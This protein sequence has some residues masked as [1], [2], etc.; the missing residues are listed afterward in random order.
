M[1]CIIISLSMK[2][3]I[4]NGNSVR[5]FFALLCWLVCICVALPTLNSA[6]AS[7]PD[8]A[9]SPSLGGIA[10]LPRIGLE[11]LS[12]N[13]LFD[14]DA[15]SG[16]GF[17]RIAMEWVNIEPDL[18]D[19][20]E[21][22]WDY[23]DYLYAQLAARGITPLVRVQKCPPW[24]CN[25]ANGPILD[26]SYNA[27]GQFMSAV[28]ERYSQP[29]YNVHF[30][31]FWNEPDG[32]GG[33]NNQLGWG[34]HPDKYVQMLSKAYAAVKAADPQ[35][36]VIMG[37]MAYD[38][39]FQDG[40]PFNP[41]FLAGVLDHGGAQ[42]LDAIAFHYYTN[43]IHGWA[44]IGMKTDAVRAVMNAHGANL[45]IV[46]TEGGLTSAPE[47]G[48][49][50]AIQ[51][52]YVV[53]MIVHGSASGLSAI[54]WF[55]D[56]DVPN[57]SPGLEIHA[58]SGLLRSDN[59][60]KPAYTAMQTFSAKIGSADYLYK[61]GEADGVNGALEGYRFRSKDGNKQV[62]VV[63]NTSG[64]DVT[65]TIPATQAGDLGA[66]TSLLG[67]NIP[68]LPGPGGT[69]LV[70]V[71]RDPVYLE[72]NSLFSDVPNGSTFY[73]YVMCL[74]GNGVLSGYID[75]TFRPSNNITRGQIAKVVSNAANFTEPVTTQ[76]FED[77]PPGSTFY[78]FV[79]RLASRN[80]TSGYACGGPGEPCGNGNLP[81]FRPNANV[82]RGQ[83]AKIVSEAA[84]YSDTP[85]GQQFEDV[86]VGSTF[87][88]YAYRLASRN[89]MSG[90]ACGG[91][92]EPC[93][94]PNNLPYFR[95]ASTAT[96]GQASKIVG[97]TFFATCQP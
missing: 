71:G 44:N 41:D 68:P 24:A 10:S 59:S 65:M 87:Y 53:Q 5:R 74:V 86:A 67:N 66:V 94:P 31:E 82:T 84:G 42:Y 9:P 63:W 58:K 77:V 23:Y 16:A 85:A 46:S 73:P 72:W 75:G 76:T 96:R 22:S 40:G 4:A 64:S 69:R 17:A 51:A 36:V 70:T 8:L 43:N 60:I 80:Y 7:P 90:Y 27:F 26:H 25:D 6:K 89:I 3:N 48:G 32:A 45:P 62:S 38:F 61:M 15:A 92:G 79:G 21:F 49:S 12:I 83:V 2:L 91:P 50:E 35:S 1:R 29:P 78:S 30:Y 28:A 13:Q 52:R 34:M 57:P 33:T 88:T 37:G 95:P 14:E 97:N 56:R 54:T 20:S 55:T 93:N 81:Y 18:T 39:W 19:P 11:T 47:Y